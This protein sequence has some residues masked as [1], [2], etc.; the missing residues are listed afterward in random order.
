MRE[1]LD[2]YR[3]LVVGGVYEF[4]GTVGS[5]TASTFAP[6][7]RRCIEEHSH[8]ST[9]IAG[10]DTNTPGY[11]FCPRLDLSQHVEIFTREEG[12]STDVEAVKRVLPTILDARWPASIP[13]WN[14]VVLPLSQRRC[15][16]GFSFSHGLGDGVSALAFHRTFLKALQEQGLGLREGENLI[17]TPQRKPLSPP[18]DTKKNLPI[19]WSF[20]S[21]PLLS[22]YLPKSFGFRAD[23]VTP[24]TWVGSPIFDSSEKY[25]TCVKIISIDAHT[26]AE[27]LEAC[28]AHGAKL[29]GLLHQFIVEALSEVLLSKFDNFIA[30]TAIDMRHAV[31]VSKDEM[32]L[33]VSG[34]VTVLHRSDKTAAEKSSFGV[35]STMTNQ[36]AAV[37]SKLQDQPVGLLRY[38][39]DMRAWTLSKLGGNRD[40]SYE[41]SNLTTF[42]PAKSAEAASIRE[43]V[44]A[45]P[46]NF[47]G[48]P[49]QF[50]VV[51]VLDGPMNI[52]VT[53]QPGA[54]G[55]GNHSEVEFVNGLCGRV[56]RS[57]VDLTTVAS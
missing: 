31:G 25:Q 18:F 51:S 26:V 1:S 17:H 36:L 2:F 46:A 10:S 50:N 7:L 34:D 4:S 33:F 35:A 55:L 5:P 11:R 19:S 14:L 30:Q 52:T 27:T 44:F 21:S 20:L 39:S 29:T 48:S 45:Q 38:L 41:I 22:T 23:M 57:F 8:L 15:F 42:K 54:L 56:E 16:I 37:S 43:M 32:G 24:T 9:T 3:S 12:A 28:R 13:P 6:A 47:T 40:T 49:L 53:W